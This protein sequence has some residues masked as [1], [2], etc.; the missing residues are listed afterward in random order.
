MTAPPPVSVLLPVR[1]GEAHLADAAASLEAQSDP[2]FEVVAV[3]DGSTDGTRAILEAWAL[4]DRRVRVL[5]QPPSG[6]VAALERARAAARGRYLARMD[7]DDACAPRRLARQRALMDRDPAVAACGAQVRYFPAEHV[8]EGAR[9]Y[10]AWLNAHATPEELERELFVECPIAHPALFARADAVAGVGGYRAPGWPED[11]D[12]V[13]RLWEAGGRLANVPEPLLWWREGA[14]RLSRTDPTY[15]P[16]AFRR[17]K[18]HFLART[19]LAGGRGAVVWGAGPVGKA[20]AR[21]LADV[22][23]PLR[24]FV[25]VDPRKLGQTIHGAPVLDTGEGLEVPGALHLAAVGQ[26]GR[27]AELRRILA[28]AG[29]VETRDFV[30]VA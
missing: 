6:I 5:S 23:V 17:C 26:P 13:L 28:G 15:A 21:A 1:D 3:D 7:A 8:R 12:L 4:R 19:L 30:A 25:E 10:E 11:Y 14:G 2:D 29:F 18:A 24:A 16:D 20:F 27:R 9:R 22:G